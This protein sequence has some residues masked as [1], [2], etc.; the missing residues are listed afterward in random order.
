MVASRSVNVAGVGGYA[1]GLKRRRDPT[2]P[3]GQLEPFTAT[4]FGELER[5]NAEQGEERKAWEHVKTE[6]TRERK[7]WKAIRKALCKELALAMSLKSEE[8][9]VAEEAIKARDAELKECN[10]KFRAFRATTDV[11]LAGTIA[12]AEAAEGSLATAEKKICAEQAANIERN[13]EHGALLQ[14][15]QAE[16]L[17]RSQE[18]AALL[19]TVEAKLCSQ[20]AINLKQGQEHAALLEHHSRLKQNCCAMQNEYAVLQQAYAAMQ[21]S[22]SAQL[23]AASAQLSAALSRASIAEAGLASTLEV[24]RTSS[25]TSTAALP[26]AAQ[27]AS[28]LQPMASWVEKI[29]HVASLPLDR[30]FLLGH[31]H[32][33]GN[34]KAAVEGLIS[35]VQAQAMTKIPCVQLTPDDRQRLV[36]YVRAGP[37]GWVWSPVMPQGYTT[38]HR[39]N[40]RSNRAGRQASHARNA[41]AASAT[42]TTTDSSATPHTTTAPNVLVA[43]PPLNAPAA[44]PVP[45]TLGVRAVNGA[46]SQ[47]SDDRGATSG[48]SRRR[49]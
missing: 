41:A 43:P 24:V 2:K 19:A 15:E 23:S 30:S 5:V 13:Q 33:N 48:R 8:A 26:L 49:I 28:H 32:R 7:E 27:V 20:E 36:E 16:K 40:A 10:E 44:A 21:E 47:E 9:F 42:A 6:Y 14:R 45:A 4:L 11:Q 37:P 25:A 12:R 46:K 29:V 22:A 1:H 31:L 17:K 35:E 39:L 34:D 38:A 18:H 3:D